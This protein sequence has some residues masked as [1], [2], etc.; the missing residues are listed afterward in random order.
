MGVAPG[1]LGVAGDTRGGV[2]IAGVLPRALCAICTEDA[3]TSACR[4]TTALISTYMV[5]RQNRKEM[6]KRVNSLSHLMHGHMPRTR[7]TLLKKVAF[8]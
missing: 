8:Q 6:T 1:S 7:G 2:I 5:L 4:M 3:S